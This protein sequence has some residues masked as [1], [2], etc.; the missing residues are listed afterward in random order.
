MAFGATQDRAD[1]TGHVDGKRQESSIPCGKENAG[2]ESSSAPPWLRTS[3]ANF[4]A[5]L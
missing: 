3:G 4:T 2:A 1:G 5:S